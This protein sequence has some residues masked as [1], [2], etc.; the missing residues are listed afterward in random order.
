MAS[1]WQS[2]PAAEC[3]PPFRLTSPLVLELRQGGGGMAVLGLPFFLAGCLITRNFLRMLFLGELGLRGSLL[4]FAA[5]GIAFTA[6]GTIFVFGRR[7]LI[8]DVSRGL[9]VR[10][11]GLLVPL[12]TRERSL[13]E[14]NAV[15]LAHDP[16][17][18]DRG[19][20]YPVRLRS[21]GGPDFVVRSPA[22]F[23]ESRTLA[24]YLSAF[25]R[26]PL[27]DT[28]QRPPDRGCPWKYAA[29]VARAWAHSSLN[30]D[31]TPAAR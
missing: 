12:R 4:T 30:S 11:L 13:S 26:L 5:I 17:D 15:V 9:L 25:L 24:E 10:R 8:I 23:G 14:F 7:W 16:G 28:I 1:T 22:R 6:I 29:D 3:P 20:T 31:A 18:S 2:G 19:E 21:V 27:V